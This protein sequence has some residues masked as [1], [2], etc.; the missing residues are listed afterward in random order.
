[1][2][3]QKQRRMQPRVSY[4][5]ACG[6]I[7][8]AGC[9]VPVVHRL[10][11]PAT[12]EHRQPEYSD[13]MR[14]DYPQ[15]TRKADDLPFRVGGATDLKTS[16]RPKLCMSLSGGGMRSA[17]FSIGVLAALEERGD[18]ARMELISGVSGGGYALAWYLV[19][20]YLAAPLGPGNRPTLMNA[21]ERDGS[22]RALFTENHLLHLRANSR[23]LTNTEAAGT[24]LLAATA[25]PIQL[26]TNGLFDWHYNTGLPQQVYRSNLTRTFLSLPDGV[27]DWARPVPSL[28]ELGEFT[29]ASGLP[30]FVFNTTAWPKSDNERDLSVD[31]AVFMFT[32]TQY[33]SGAYGFYRYADDPAIDGA[34]Q[35]LDPISVDDVMLRSGGAVDL[36]AGVESNVLRTALSSLAVNLGGYIK[37][38]AIDPSVRDFHNVLPFPFYFPKRNDLL[39][40][41]IYISDGGHLENLGLLAPI[42][43][44]CEHVVV[45]DA[46]HDPHYKFEAYR[47]LRAALQPNFSLDVEN[48]PTEGASSD[49]V[50]SQ[51][52]SR[53]SAWSK[54]AERP[55][56]H[57]AVSR[58]GQKLIDITYVKLAYKPQ[59]DKSDPNSVGAESAAEFL[60]TSPGTSGAFYKDWTSSSDECMP[61]MEGTPVYEHYYYCIQ[62]ERAHK[63]AFAYVDTLGRASDPFPQQPTLDQNFSSEQFQAYVELGRSVGRIAAEALP[64]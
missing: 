6:C 1:M 22:R 21:A 53:E 64:H 33:G 51:E 38:P 8:L 42:L 61:R 35:R 15:I 16:A 17:S 46:E 9:A 57:G 59:P 63:P 37:N 12:V 62:Q 47:K 55:V 20:Q 27:T 40:T 4:A 10:D 44:G 50:D 30:A 28:F 31:Q 60:A 14:P 48:A 2:T 49:A 18:L 29:R 19:Q 24:V 39:G 32:D 54:F 43:Y 26:F 58:G 56:L 5:A 36:N 7:F 25:L 52:P 11:I 45:V 3:R 23:L 41:G 13:H 34:R